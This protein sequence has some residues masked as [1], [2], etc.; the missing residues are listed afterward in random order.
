M[1]TFPELG[2]P[3]HLFIDL[4]ETLITTWNDAHLGRKQIVEMLLCE[5]F[6]G[7]PNGEKLDATVWSFALTNNKDRDYFNTNLKNWLSE[8]YHLN[9]IEVPITQNIAE[10]SRDFTGKK[11]TYTYQILADYGKEG[12]LSHWVR[13]RDMHDCEIV[14]LDDLVEDKRTSFYNR[15]LHITCVKV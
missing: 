14:L 5:H 4:E 6:P 11:N 12:T 13:M 9:F 7:Y 8:N 15:N 2:L 1:T 10:H 3:K